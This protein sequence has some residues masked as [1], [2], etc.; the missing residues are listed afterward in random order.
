MTSGTAIAI[1]P[2]NLLIMNEC[3]G[4]GVRKKCLYNSDC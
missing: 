3:G 1:E 4:K 2:Q